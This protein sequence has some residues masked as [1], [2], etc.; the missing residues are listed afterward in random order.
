M[1]EEDTSHDGMDIHTSIHMYVQCTH[2]RIH[3]H[4]DTQVHNTHIHCRYIRTYVRTY[5]QTSVL[6]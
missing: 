6:H 2:I 5:T 4:T 1:M 3:I